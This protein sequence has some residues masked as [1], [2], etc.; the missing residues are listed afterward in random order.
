[1][2]RGRGVAGY[3]IRQVPQTRVVDTTSRGTTPLD[4]S[5]I[6]GMGKVTQ[7]ASCLS[8]TRETHREYGP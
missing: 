7:E 5:Y 3:V 6:W 8:G 2:V 4:A 1:M